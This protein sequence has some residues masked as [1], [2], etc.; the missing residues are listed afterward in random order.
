MASSLLIYSDIHVFV[1]SCSSIKSN[2]F[3]ANLSQTTK[4]HPSKLTEL[5]DHNFK[6]DK[7]QKVLQM[8][9]KQCGKG[10]IARYVEFLL[11]PQHTA[12]KYEQF[13]LFRQCFR[14]PCTAD[15]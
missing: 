7:W 15:M 2:H 13:L 5:A 3:S 6:S 9:R 4:L 8:G 12:D 10:E 14:K 11:F 1:V